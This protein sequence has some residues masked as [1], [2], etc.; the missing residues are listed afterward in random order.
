MVHASFAIVRPKYRLTL[1]VALLALGL[2][3]CSRIHDTKGYIVDDELMGALHA[4]VDNK[5]SVQQTMGRPTLSGT[6]DNNTWYYV[7]QNT[8][9]LAFLKPKAEKHQVM[10]LHFDDK[11]KLIKMEKM[12]MHEIVEVRPAPGKTATRG[13]E[14]T[15]WEQFFGNIGALGPGGPKGG[16]PG[17]DGG[18]GG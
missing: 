17:G 5:K 1:G 15:F 6:F 14:L 7:S 8:E 18:D 3:G 13:K 16:K 12:G 10:A 2:S 11:G 9:R 4:G